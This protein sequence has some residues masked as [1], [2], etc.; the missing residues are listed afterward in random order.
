MKNSKQELWNRL[1]ALQT[2]ED[3]FRLMRSLVTVPAA[4]ALLPEG[5]ER[6]SVLGMHCQMCSNEVHSTQLGWVHFGNTVKCL[7]V[8]RACHSTRDGLSTERIMMSM[9][10][11]RW[12]LSQSLGAKSQPRWSFDLLSSF[13]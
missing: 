6:G 13:V 4:I 11:G 5:N 7:P 2:T 9:K 12:L 8:H 3:L 1:Q 10:I